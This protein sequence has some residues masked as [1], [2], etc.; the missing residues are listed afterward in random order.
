MTKIF[1]K[2]WLYL[3]IIVIAVVAAINM[4]TNANR[5][6]LS[7]MELANAEALAQGEVIVGIPCAEVCKMCWCMWFWD[8]GE[9]DEAEGEPYV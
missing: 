6:G 4:N 2:I 3:A 1:K 8:D 5:Y 9:V 7:D